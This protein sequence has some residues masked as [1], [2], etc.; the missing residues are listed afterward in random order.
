[1]NLIG[2]TVRTIPLNLE[3]NDRI[4]DLH[5][6]ADTTFVAFGFYTDSLAVDRMPYVA[7]IDTNG[8][9]LW[10]KT[11]NKAGFE[12]YIINLEPT[13]D[14]GYVFSGTEEE[15]PNGQTDLFLTKVDSVGN[16]VWK[17]YYHELLSQRGGHVE[18]LAD[19]NFAMF[20]TG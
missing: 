16:L 11:H 4:H 14:G 2:D 9:V 12:E 1:M 7:N 19:G 3:F 10:F 8:N 5:V 17:Q 13:P 20:S 15:T 18:V 6:K